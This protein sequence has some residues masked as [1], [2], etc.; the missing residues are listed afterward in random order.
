MRCRF[1]GSTLIHSA[2]DH[3]NFSAGKAFA[4]TIVFGP[5]GAGAGMLGKDI[6][7]FRCTQ[8]GAFMESP[9]D[10]T[11][12]KMVNDAV[13]SAK[14]GTSYIS[15]NFYKG[16]YPN[17]ENVQTAEKSNAERVSLHLSENTNTVKAINA[18]KD[19]MKVKRSFNTNLWDPSCPVFIR[20][21]IIKTGT[22]GDVLSFG[23]IN[24][25]D[26]TIRSLYLQ[27]LVL[28]DTGDEITTIQCVY[29]GDNVEPGDSFSLDKAFTVGSDLAYKAEVTCEKAAF[30]DDSVWRAEN[31][32]KAYAVELSEI[33]EFPRF[34]YL[35]HEYNKI[36]EEKGVVRRNKHGRYIKT[37]RPEYLPIK[38]EGDGYWTCT[39]GMP[40]RINS[41]CPVCK[42]SYEELQ[43]LFSQEYL[44]KIQHDAVFQRASERA[45]E[46]VGYREKLDKIIEEK[47]ASEYEKA[48]S[49]KGSESIAQ[50]TDAVGLL[51]NLGDYKDAKKITAEYH[52]RI[53]ELKAKEEKKREEEKKR[54]AVIAEE[55]A[56][57]AAKEAEILLQRKRKKE[58]LIMFALFAVIAILAIYAMVVN[59][60]IPNNKYKSA[61]SLMENGEYEN[62]IEEFKALKG[63]KDSDSKIK[64]CQ[65][66]D[67]ARGIYP[68][69][70]SLFNDGLYAEAYSLLK[71]IDEDGPSRELMSEIESKKP[72]FLLEAGDTFTFGEYEQDNNLENGKEPIE[73]VV[74]ANNTEKNKLLVISKEI[75]DCMTYYNKKENVTWESCSPREWLNTSFYDSAFLESEKEAIDQTNVTDSD[76]F[77]YSVDGG[78]DTND[79]LFYLSLREI[80]Q[81]YSYKVDPINAQRKM[82]CECTPYAISQGAVADNNGYGCWLLRTPG[83]ETFGVCYIAVNGVVCGDNSTSDGQKGVYVN[84]KGSGVRPAMN[85]DG[86][87]LQS[88]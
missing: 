86:N 70:E 38:N 47:K 21:T 43:K 63:Y 44:A 2:H 78:N 13:Y 40:V 30:T 37:W 64:E 6:E 4:G 73:W 15:Y 61:I 10:T 23:I 60:I 68:K 53:E 35:F 14:K 31:G 42:C 16:Q 83:A 19:T 88:H 11:T 76:N 52:S 9:M 59:F 20:N 34:K 50:L 49:A 66:R 27:A 85:I 39:C 67:K 7:G 28:D 56:K 29:Q 58:K 3:K 71:S 24:Q 77:V 5:M 81:Y 84:G 1:C 79:R 26:K 72:L 45:A 82:K 32:T 8:C 65:A 62:A 74:L 46:T 18:E 51:D 69:A 36:L 54:A 22:N 55:R 33:T 41:T 57:Q 25:S 48:L 17:I 75:L 80:Y 12:E 87:Y